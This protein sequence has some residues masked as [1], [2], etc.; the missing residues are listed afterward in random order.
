MCFLDYET[1][2]TL[3]GWEHAAERLCQGRIGVEQRAPSRIFEV[4]HIFMHIERQY[5]LKISL[6]ESQVHSCYDPS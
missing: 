3:D 1:L 4:M 2:K 6:R 5:D